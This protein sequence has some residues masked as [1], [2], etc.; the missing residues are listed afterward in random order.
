MPSFVP[1]VLMVHKT[2]L[3][4]PLGRDVKKRLEDRG[5]HTIVYDGKIPALVRKSFREGFLCSKRMMVLSVW[6]D[7]GFQTCR[8]SA[9]YQL[10]L[11]SGCPGLCEYCYLNTNLGRRPY[12]KINV[13]VGDVLRRA[14]EYVR[15]RLPEATVFEG[16]ATSDPVAVEG[17]TGSLRRAVEFIASLDGAGFRFVTKYTDVEGLT[18]ITHGGKTEIRF[19]INCDPVIAKYETG[20]PRL[21]SRLKAAGVCARA[22]YP[23]GFLV[24]PIFYFEGWRGEYKRMLRAAAE[25]LGNNISTFELITH[26]FTVRSRDIIRQAYPETQVPLDETERVFKFGQFGYGKYVYPPELYAEIKE[27]FTAI[28]AELFPRARMLYFV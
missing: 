14:G 17:W 20:V 24:A 28:I 13:N 5:V 12:I 26:R 23:V 2:A 21:T 6:K 22:G 9:D 19:S 4:Y 11:V 15:E 3:D 1:E 10:P 16:A 27:F 8:P 7:R 18:G 25:Q